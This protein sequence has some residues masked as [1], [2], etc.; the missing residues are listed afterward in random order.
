MEEQRDGVFRS[1]DAVDTGKRNARF[2]RPGET[3]KLGLQS[4][5]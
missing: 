1:V 2:V 3:S 5:I 4:C